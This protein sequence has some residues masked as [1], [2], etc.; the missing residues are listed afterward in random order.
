MVYKI[1]W[2]VIDLFLWNKHFVKIVEE[3]FTVSRLSSYAVL[4]VD[5]EDVFFV[6]V[7]E[8]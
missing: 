4:S 1:I 8:K 3:Y 5:V 6:I 7:E 2:F